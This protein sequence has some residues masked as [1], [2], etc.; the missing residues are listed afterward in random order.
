MKYLPGVTISLLICRLLLRDPW[1]IF[2]TWKLIDAIR[3]TYG[4]KL[5]ELI[6][7]SPRFGVLIACMIVSII[8]MLT[9]IIVTALHVTHDSG[10]NPYWRVSIVHNL[11]S[12]YLVYLLTLLKVC[13]G[14]QM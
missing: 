6:H 3:K 9:D 8:F 1:W 4:F 5:L 10:I 14:V 7:I 12:S 2:T 13:F 11:V